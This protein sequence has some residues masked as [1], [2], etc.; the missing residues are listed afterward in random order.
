MFSMCVD[1]GRV[2]ATTEYCCTLE[3][4]GP[5]EG[6]VM[7]DGFVGESLRTMTGAE[8]RKCEW[9]TADDVCCAFVSQFE[10]I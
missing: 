2:V 6:L 4:R 9:R 3:R 5:T 8:N 1:S 10:G 7:C